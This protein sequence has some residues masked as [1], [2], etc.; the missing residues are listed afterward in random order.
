MKK[1]LLIST[2]L[3]F[4]GSVF[5]ANISIH[6]T[7][8]SVVT[9]DDTKSTYSPD[10]W[11]EA[12]WLH[13]QEI[14]PGTFSAPY[15]NGDETSWDDNYVH[16]ITGALLPS[17]HWNN[18]YRSGVRGN[19]ITL[20]GPWLG[21]NRS[22]EFFRHS[23]NFG[24]DSTNLVIWDLP[25]FINTSSPIPNSSH[26]DTMEA[27]LFS[28]QTQ[29]PF[30][31]T[32]G[33]LTMTVY[34]VDVKRD[35]VTIQPSVDT[36]GDGL[37]DYE[38]NCTLIPNPNQEDTDNDDYGNICDGDLDNSGFVNSIDLSLFKQRLFSNDPDADLDSSGVVNSIDFSL[39][40]TLLLSPPGPSGLI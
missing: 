31:Q 14:N 2:M 28:R 5:A 32:V 12:K 20:T 16:F 33:T 18:P 15:F 38:D 22:R 39:F 3:A 37:Y 35:G 9:Y 10:R 36:D 8:G 25:T 29:V 6:F 4:A 21:H 11:R 23:R 34:I 7:S 30:I 24:T 1:I 19:G 27:L 40:K 26:L 13:E 17:R